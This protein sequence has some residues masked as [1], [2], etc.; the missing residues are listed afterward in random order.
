MN[1]AVRKEIRLLL[2]AWIVAMLAATV[3]VGLAGSSWWGNGDFASLEVALCFV[4]FAAGAMLLSL[5]SFGMEM[6]LGTFPSLLAQPRARLDTWQMKIGVLA[7]A[8]ASVVVASGFSWW[9]WSGAPLTESRLWL[10]HFKYILLLTLIAFAGGLWTTLLF[11]QMVAAFW[12]AIVVPF[13]LYSAIEPLMERLLDEDDASFFRAAL[14]VASCGYAVLGYG[15]ARWMFL[16][17]QDKQAQEAANTGAWSLLPA[18]PKPRWPV[19]ALLLKELR[20]QQGTLLIGIVLLV[21]H[22]SALAA[23]EYFPLLEVKYFKLNDLFFV[24]MVVPLVV[25]CASFAEERRCQTIQGTL[26]LPIRRIFQFIIKLLV[27]F[28]VGIFLG[29][30]MPLLLAQLHPSQGPQDSAIKG[31]V[32]AAAIITA[33]GCLASSLSSTLLQALGATI[34]F[35][36]TAVVV[37]ISFPYLAVAFKDAYGYLSWPVLIAAC[38]CL[39]YANFKQLRITWR[40]GLLNVA[41]L[42]AVV[43]A[44]CVITG[45]NRN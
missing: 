38:A 17:A 8:L 33:I 5:S 45:A 31:L 22:L 41:V 28:G 44:L 26:C 40:R 15:L 34:G 37:L 16:H 9:L 2:P 11:R 6:S 42:I 19:A 3:P 36:L 27:V 32:L 14:C 24:W 35:F 18:F 13:V 29:A 21:L 4:L 43:F 39:G 10:S 23:S 20:L 30:V 25:G 12:F 1:A 7:L